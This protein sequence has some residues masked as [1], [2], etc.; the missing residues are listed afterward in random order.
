MGMDVAMQRTSTFRLSQR[1]DRVEP[2]VGLLELPSAK[3]LGSPSMEALGVPASGIKT[4]T[5]LS[6]ASSSTVGLGLGLD[7]P[8]MRT[9]LAGASSS[10]VEVDHRV[11]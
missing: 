8:G 3:P 6:G 2:V 11:P 10:T 1:F 5:S 4:M 7:V 9:N